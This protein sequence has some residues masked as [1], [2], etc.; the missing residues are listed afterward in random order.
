MQEVLAE[1]TS[2]G[3]PCCLA[4]SRQRQIRLFLESASSSSRVEEGASARSAAAVAAAV[5]GIP[6]FAAAAGVRLS[7]CIESLW[8]LPP[9][10][11][12]SS[13][14]GSDA[15]TFGNNSQK[16]P[17]RQ[18]Q[19]RS[20]QRLRPVSLDISSAGGESP[21]LKQCC[22]N[23]GWRIA[24]SFFAAG[25]KRNLKS[26]PVL[27]KSVL[28]HASVDYFATCDQPTSTGLEMR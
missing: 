20:S 13:L 28:C 26:R 14:S 16:K 27:M 8:N 17:R 23:L 21:L 18:L 11:A 12:L 2:G 10:K 3:L 22:A 15:S 7:E 25:E 19:P 6:A 4:C 24:D 5:V 1:P 9:L